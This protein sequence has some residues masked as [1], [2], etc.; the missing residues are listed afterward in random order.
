[1]ALSLRFPQTQQYA[2]IPRVLLMDNQYLHEQEHEHVVNP[3]ARLALRHGSQGNVVGSTRQD[4]TGILRSVI[5]ALRMV[6]SASHRP[7]D[8]RDQSSV[9]GWLSQSIPTVPMYIFQTLY[10]LV[11]VSSTRDLRVQNYFTTP[12]VHRSLMSPS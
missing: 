2:T 9:S 10:H 3:D 12:N 1:M 4:R 5:P 6:W 8:Q 7:V 11:L